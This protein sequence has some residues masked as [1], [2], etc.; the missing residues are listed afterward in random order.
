MLGETRQV[1]LVDDEEAL[2]DLGHAMLMRCGPEALRYASPF[3][4][5]SHDKR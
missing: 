5:S 2:L 4:C 1:L 3:L